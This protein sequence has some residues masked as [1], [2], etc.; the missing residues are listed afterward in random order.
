MFN[1]KK[2]LIEYSSSNE[3]LEKE[4]KNATLHAL[5]VFAENLRLDNVLYISNAT[6]LPAYTSERGVGFGPYDVNSITH[7]SL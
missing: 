5:G 7:D 6:E 4:L 2:I 1:K 3:N